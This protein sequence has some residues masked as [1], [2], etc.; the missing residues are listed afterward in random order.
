MMIAA[1]LAICNLPQPRK[2][3]CFSIKPK[4]YLIN[5]ILIFSVFISYLFCKCFSGSVVVDVGFEKG[6]VKCE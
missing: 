5:F 3:R 1:F 4:A 2:R 6:N